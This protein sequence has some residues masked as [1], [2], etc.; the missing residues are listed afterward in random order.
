[1]ETAWTKYQDR[2]LKSQSGPAEARVKRSP[3]ASFT[4]AVDAMRERVRHTDASA[5]SEAELAAAHDSLGLLQED[6]AGF[7]YPAGGSNLT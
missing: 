6:I 5:W 4:L 7:P 1:M 2:V 3:G